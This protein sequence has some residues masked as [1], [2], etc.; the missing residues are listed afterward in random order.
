MDVRLPD[1]R[2]LNGVPEGTTKEQIAGKLKANGMTVP[3]EWMTPKRTTMQRVGAEAAQVA[4]MALGFPAFVAQVGATG[5]VDIAG[6]LAGKEKPLERGSK[7]IGEAMQKPWMK[8]L[9]APIQT[10]L[11]TDTKGTT[12]QALSEHISGP[13]ERAAEYWSEKADNTE[14]GEALKQAVNIAMTKGGDVVLDVAGRPI[15]KAREKAAHEAAKEKPTPTTPPVQPTEA[16]PAASE[17]HAFGGMPDIEEPSLAKPM[18]EQARQAKQLKK[19]RESAEFEAWIDEQ[20]ASDLSDMP[21][22]QEA[23]KIAPAPVYEGIDREAKLMLPTESG[24]MVHMPVIMKRGNSYAGARVEGLTDVDRAS[25]AIAKGGESFQPKSH[26]TKQ[27]GEAL[28]RAGIPLE[29]AKQ[30]GEKLMEEIKRQHAEN[31]QANGGRW[32]NPEG[33]SLPIYPHGRPVGMTAERA[34]AEHSVQEIQRIVEKKVGIHEEPMP[35]QA[36]LSTLDKLKNPVARGVAAAGLI[37]ASESAK[38]DGGS[39]TTTSNMLAYAG[40][41][42]ALGVGYANRNQIKAAMSAGLRDTLQNVFRDVKETGAKPIVDKWKAYFE[43]A[44]RRIVGASAKIVKRNKGIQIHELEANP[45]FQSN[46]A[47]IAKMYQEARWKDKENLSM[48]LGA[49]FDHWDE[50]DP[51][52]K[53]M[54]EAYKSNKE[55]TITFPMFA[56][57]EGWN[58]MRAGLIEGMKLKGKDSGQVFSSFSLTAF[59]KVALG[60]QIRALKNLKLPNGKTA[61]SQ[62]EPGYVKIS[63]AWGGTLSDLEGWLIHPDLVNDFKLSFDTYKPGAISKTLMGINLAVKR[64]E[65]GLSG[66]HA[67]SLG[68]A[69]LNDVVGRVL[70]GDTPSMDGIAAARNIYEQGGKPIIGGMDALDL[71]L[72]HGLVLKGPIEATMGKETA[73]HALDA[74]AEALDRTGLKLGLVA[75]GIKEADKAVQKFTW[76]YLHTNFKIMTF[77]KEFERQAAKNPEKDV[78]KIAEEVAEYTNDIFG[79]VDWRRIGYQFKSRWGRNLAADVFSGQGKFWMDMAMFAPDWFFATTRSW[80]RALPRMKDGKIIWDDKS[81][82]YTRYLIGGAMA[83]IAVGEG[84][85]YALSGH[86]MQDNESPKKDAT[87]SDKI[88]AMMMVDMGDGRLMQLSKHFTDFPEMAIH[89]GKTVANKM[90]VAPSTALEMLMNK[91][92]LQSPYPITYSNA[93]GYM[94]PT[95]VKDVAEFMGKKVLPISVQ[96]IT[97][98]G[99]L[100]DRLSRAGLGMIGVPPRG[101]TPDELAAMREAEKEKKAAARE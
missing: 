71:G 52:T 30:H 94:S 57:E 78:H 89:P 96:A 56:Y 43:I 55:K 47:Y 17:A 39:D 38:A 28:E 41:A 83:Y 66:F 91:P 80:V 51:R 65:V 54:I 23:K 98:E 8:F 58:G 62:T 4:D 19:E 9:S 50:K 18:K 77:L 60:Q 86:G 46:T 100:S 81:K 20:G 76:D 70:T 95:G 35:I 2:M 79:S 69:K 90:G 3:D 26:T 97:G 36:H 64:S 33:N 88:E 73:Y 53:E 15:V 10:M 40:V 13:V 34:V 59:E 75:K 37:V 63:E 99:D 101:R 16:A 68:Q 42:L 32:N 27:L 93:P 25:I 72:S 5:A 61:M 6:A 84:L 49:A 74:T 7:I 29:R 82:L 44:S 1:G 48:S 92:Y 31:V 21:L 11:G 14:F 85:N 24:E 22:P 67:M 45:E 87:D 12:M